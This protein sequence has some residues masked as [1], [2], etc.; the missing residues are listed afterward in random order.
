[1]Y[2]KTSKTLSEEFY[3][4]TFIIL[5]YCYL[6]NIFYNILKGDIITLAPWV[7]ECKYAHQYKTEVKRTLEN[8]K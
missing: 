1:M 4:I 5:R 3:G 8:H 7:D 6:A 2:F